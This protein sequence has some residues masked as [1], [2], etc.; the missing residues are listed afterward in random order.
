[1]IS[2]PLC[3]KSIWCKWVYSIKYNLDGSIERY[4]TR[5]VILGNKQVEGL[6]YNET[7]ARVDEMLIVC[8]FVVVDVTKN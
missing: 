8:T 2:L 3:K 6:N 4:K 7:F 1:M 5:L